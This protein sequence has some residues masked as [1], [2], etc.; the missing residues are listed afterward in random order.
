M[1]FIKMPLACVENRVAEAKGE[2]GE[3]RTRGGGGLSA[4]RDRG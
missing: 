1:Y 3:G 2:E 4:C